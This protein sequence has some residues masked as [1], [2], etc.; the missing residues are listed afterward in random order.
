[1]T[2]DDKSPM[3]SI[4]QNLLTIKNQIHQFEAQYHRLS[5][6]VKLIAATKTQ[7]IET[8]LQAI[9]AGQTLFGENY[10]QEALPK[11]EYFE[12]NPPV[13]PLEWHFIGSVQN[14]KTKKIAEHF[15]WVHTIDSLK[16]ATRLNDQRPDHLP[17]L[18]I[19]L[20]VNVS[21]EMSKSGIFL[22][23]VLA[24]AEHCN[25]LSR[26]KFRGL[27]TI[28]AY[29]NSLVDKRQQLH[30]LKLMFEELRA[31]QFS[32]DTLSM[33]MSDDLEAAIAEGSTLVRV[34]TGIFGKR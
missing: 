6:S 17:P 8:I 26:L 20:E 9:A 12:K 19:C 33:G 4:Q 27:M 13:T 5:G 31:R 3:I 34:G 29:K 1:M 22:D 10:L 14:N 32:V 16:T 24:L 21:E 28:P 15:S 2:Q 11:I 23:E 7:S 18:N 25:R 30:P